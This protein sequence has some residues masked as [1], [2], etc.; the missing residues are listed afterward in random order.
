MSKRL[1]G[2]PEWPEM[3]ALFERSRRDGDP[4]VRNEIIV[5]YLPLARR[6]ASRYQSRTVALEELEQVA[7][8]GLV[9]AVD[10]FDLDRGIPFPAFAT[11][12]VL[13]ELRR[14]FRDKSWAVR[15]P[16]RL[17]D[18]MREVVAARQELAQELGRE[19][20][21]GELAARVGVNVDDVL[22]ATE[23][24]S[25]YRCR[26]L[27]APLRADDPG[28]TLAEVVVDDQDRDYE[29]VDDLL[30]LRSYL[31]RLPLRER[32]ILQ[33]RFID[34]WTQTRIGAEL[35]ISQMH[36]CRLLTKTLDRLHEQMLQD[37]EP[38]ASAA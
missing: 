5:A 3:A 20:T 19:A 18:L 7:C 37:R 11:V 31:H 4:A 27:D 33:L 22:A 35:G 15:P 23:A 32:R 6:L 25:A 34:G 9:L 36:V 14:H 17:Q 30:T 12:T 28:R 24:G 26:S 1:D 2:V 10:R 21:V 13:G 29:L 16:R 8:L 38:A